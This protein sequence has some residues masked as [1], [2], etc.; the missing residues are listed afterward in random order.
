MPVADDVAG[1]AQEGR[2]KLLTLRVQF[3]GRAPEDKVEVRLNGDVLK[4]TKEDAKSG[5]VTYSAD[6]SQYRHGDNAIAL[7]V[8][9]SREKAKPVVVASVEL[10]VDYN[11]GLSNS[12]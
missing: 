5:W 6:P 2:L 12:K 9:D 1:A 8:S 3:E 4:S 11:D 7:R 10:R